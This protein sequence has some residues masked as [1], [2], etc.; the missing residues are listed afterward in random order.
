[1]TEM[2]VDENTSEDERISE[3]LGAETE[4]KSKKWLVSLL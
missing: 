3:I 4:L 1:M 2:T